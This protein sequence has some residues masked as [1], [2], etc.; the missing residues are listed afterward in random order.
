MEAVR[1]ETGGGASVLHFTRRGHSNNT[2]RNG[3][4]ISAA[5]NIGGEKG[6]MGELHPQRC[7]REA[8]LILHY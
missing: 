6:N 2:F 5:S 4:F 8:N 7:D 1:D 3:L